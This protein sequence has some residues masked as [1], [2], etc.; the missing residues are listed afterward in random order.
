MVEVLLAARETG[1]VVRV[2][3]LVAVLQ[4]IPVP[5]RLDVAV[6]EP[7]EF[8][9]AS[10]RVGVDLFLSSSL[11]VLPDD[12][13][14]GETE[15]NTTTVQYN[16]PI[17]NNYTLGKTLQSELSFYS[18][19]YIFLNNLVLYEKVYNLKTSFWN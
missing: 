19:I 1:A 13:C 15:N 8:C 12:L 16:F 2:V 14:I 17:P 4:D 18:Y 7:L 11:L 10:E 6:L 9:K 5:E 3:A